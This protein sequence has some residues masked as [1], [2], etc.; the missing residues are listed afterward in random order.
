M[1]HSVW[2]AAAVALGIAA[3]ATAADGVRIKLGA[4]GLESLTYDGVEYVDP[5]GVGVAAFET[6]PTTTRVDGNTVEQTY[7]W[8]PPWSASA[9]TAG[10]P[11]LSEVVPKRIQNPF[12]PTDSAE[13]P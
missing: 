5:S 4:R 11:H 3:P 2:L 6:K 7:P 8:P 10:C 9:T 1:R 13:D 12:L